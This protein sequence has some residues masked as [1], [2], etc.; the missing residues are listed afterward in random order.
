L[1]KPE[2]EMQEA[3][4]VEMQKVK[5]KVEMQRQ[6]ILNL[7]VMVMKEIWLKV[8]SL[9]AAQQAEQAAKQEAEQ[10]AKQEAAMHHR[11]I[12]SASIIHDISIGKGAELFR[13]LVT[14]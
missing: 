3:V 9:L 14:V 10:A 7:M 12:S 4:E 2:V 8:V 13:V 1:E 11:H 6:A 5:R